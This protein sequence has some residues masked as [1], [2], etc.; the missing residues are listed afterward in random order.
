VRG[1]APWVGIHPSIQPTSERAGGRVC[2]PVRQ[3]RGELALPGGGIKGIGHRGWRGPPYT[4]VGGIPGASAHFPLGRR[5]PPDR[6]LPQRVVSASAHEWNLFGRWF[7]TRD[8]RLDTR[9]CTRDR[10]RCANHTPTHSAQRTAARRSV[11]CSAPLWRRQQ[12]AS[13]APLLSSVE[14][15]A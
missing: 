14:K 11:S 1:S 7:W 10:K 8:P 13:I 9:L 6:D 4:A 2:R 15:W 12:F 3:Y 5:S